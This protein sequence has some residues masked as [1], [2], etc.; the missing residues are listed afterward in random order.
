MGYQADQQGIINRYLREAGGWDSHLL[1]CREYIL[2]S[3]KLHSPETISILG[4]GW[5][6]DVPVEELAGLCKKVQLVDIIH[7]PQIKHKVKALNNVELISD[8]ITGGMIKRSGELRKNGVET[9][10]NS[11]I[12][13]Y[14]PD[15]DP[16]LVISLNILTQTDTLIVDYLNQKFGISYSDLRD[17]R[18]KIQGAH[19]SFLDSGPS[20]LISD[21]E[22]LVYDKDELVQTNKLLF[23]DLS[24]E[25]ERRDWIWD[26]DNSGEYYKR[27]R[28]CF[29]VIAIDNAK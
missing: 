20:I 15:Y 19:I 16:G 17:L 28:I 18:G 23:T 3:V 11:E 29:K 24:C 1:N 4:S 14:Q 10:L 2:E 26:F 25:G 22:E 12:P 13:V 5:L 6:L 21:Y 27:K 7:P 8:D 9:M